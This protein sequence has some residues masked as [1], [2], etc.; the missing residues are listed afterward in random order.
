MKVNIWS[1]SPATRYL[2]FKN[3]HKGEVAQLFTMI[4]QQ[5]SLFQEPCAYI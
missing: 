4:K 5:F 2:G 3:Y 1:D